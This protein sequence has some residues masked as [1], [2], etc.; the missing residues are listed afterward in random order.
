MTEGEYIEATNLA[1][2]RVAVDV[3]RDVRPGYGPVTKERKHQIYASLSDLLDEC[4][5]AID[6]SG[7]DETEM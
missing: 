5:A 6:T 1:K 3:L 7:D 4:F 2:I